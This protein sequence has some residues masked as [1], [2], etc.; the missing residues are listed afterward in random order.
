MNI[1]EAIEILNKN[2]GREY[3]IPEEFRTQEVY[4]KYFKLCK[5]I[6]HIPSKYLT[7]DMCNEY[8]KITKEIYDIPPQ[9]ITEDMVDEFNKLFRQK[10]NLS[11]IQQNLSLN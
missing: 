1:N 4:D 7:Q 8:F 6:Y 3:S 5:D 10:L 9:Y 2:F 11:D